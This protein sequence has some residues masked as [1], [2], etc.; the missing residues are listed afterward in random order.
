VDDTARS[1]LDFDLAHGK[2]KGTS[3]AV[4]AE[5]R[6]EADAVDADR[7]KINEL[8]EAARLDKR[9]AAI[10]AASDA[11]A[12]NNRQQRIAQELAQIDATKLPQGTQAYEQRAKAI[13]D[14]V[15][16]DEARLTVRRLADQSLSTD[17]E[18]AKL[19]QETAAMTQNT[20]QRQ[21]ATYQLKLEAEAR[22]EIAASPDMADTI[23]GA[24]AEE[25]ARY[26]AA[27]TD[28]YAAQNDAVNGLTASVARYQEQATQS[29][30]IAG[31]IFTRTADS[32][33]DAITRGV[34]TGKLQFKDLWAT[35]VQEAVSAKIR[36]SVASFATSVNWVGLAAA[37][38][39]AG[40]GSNSGAAGSSAGAAPGSTGTSSFGQPV[41]HLAGGGNP[42][43]NR[44][45]LVGEVG[46][47]L[48]VPRVPG[49]I[50][51]NAALGEL[52]GPRLQINM[53]NNIG[54]QV[55]RADLEA[56]MVQ[57]SRVTEARIFNR[58]TR[59]GVLRA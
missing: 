20:L 57:A 48:F 10:K 2:L 5:L 1:V 38:A 13:R 41:M 46:P 6:K 22:K 17:A 3:A 30:R 12:L 56:G 18:V 24:K 28:A 50:F 31:E 27:A 26:T 53:N 34:T 29:G 19:E 40:A 11:Q 58:L 54:A 14:A 45:N 39:G 7:R 25:L 59:M 32:L 47:E 43:V 33:V 35:F 16:A 55:G 44:I 42:S 36:A 23:K 21:I 9:V 52:G 51:P 15:N 4:A 8:G 49:T 37:F